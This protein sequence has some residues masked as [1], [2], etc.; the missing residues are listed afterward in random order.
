MENGKYNRYNIMVEIK[1]E[2]GIT[3]EVDSSWGI[4]LDFLVRDIRNLETREGSRSRVLLLEGTDLN[5]TLLGSIF[6]INIETGDFNRRKRVPCELLS[7]GVVLMEGY[8]QLLRINNKLGSKT[9]EVEVFDKVIK[10]FMDLEEKLITGNDNV[11]WDLDFSQWDHTLRIE[12]VEESRT[13]TD[14]PYYYLEFYTNNKIR[15]NINE[16]SP[17]FKIKDIWDL[18]FVKWGVSYKSEFLNSDYFKQLVMP[19]GGDREWI[20]ERS[21]DLEVGWL[22]ASPC[23]HYIGNRING[24]DPN[25]AFLSSEQ[26]GSNIIQLFS[27]LQNN[28]TFS[29]GY[30]GGPVTGQPPQNSGGTRR[31][32]YPLNDFIKGTSEGPVTCRF[33]TSPPSSQMINP[34]GSFAPVRMANI[35]R[36]KTLTWAKMDIN[37]TLDLQLSVRNNNNEAAFAKIIDLDSIEI[38]TTSGAVGNVVDLDFIDN[39]PMRLKIHLCVNL[40]TNPVGNEFY[41]HADM[42]KKS[43]AQVEWSGLNYPNIGSNTTITEDF[44]ITGQFRDVP[45]SRDGNFIIV[46]EVLDSTSYYDI[47]GRVSTATPNSGWFGGGLRYGRK[48]Y[49]YEPITS[50]VELKLRLGGDNTHVEAVFR[51]QILAEFNPVKLNRFLPKELSQKDFIKGVMNMFNL[52]LMPLKSGNEDFFIE[53]RDEFYKSGKII[54]IRNNNL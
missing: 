8:F 29:G 11:E 12:R 46:V 19:W 42:I 41:S 51:E 18:I 32:Q 34:P 23:Y 1:L 6:N 28:Y 22:T 9:Y 26:L 21:L 4:K 16:V 53:P 25:E 38:G 50:P 15:T 48:T 35:Q 36:V 47:P 20:L 3:L 5:N 40:D 10:F 7:D 54:D 43:I 31:I 27:D 14:L 49:N 37:F 2:G 44:T 52:Q 13:R 17:G 45:V 33:T 30:I 24:S 39:P